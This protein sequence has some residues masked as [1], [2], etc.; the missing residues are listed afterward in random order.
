MSDTEET[1]GTAPEKPQ[2]T[3][4][5]RHWKGITA[6]TTI[7]TAGLLGGLFAPR[8][9]GE[10]PPMAP[11]K[12]PKE[13]LTEAEARLVRINELA[14]LIANTPEEAERETYVRLHQSE[15]VIGIREKRLPED[16]T[17]E[18]LQ[19]SAR[20][21]NAL[22]PMEESAEGKHE[23]LTAVQGFLKDIEQKT[24]IPTPDI[25]LGPSYERW[26]DIKREVD[27]H[28]EILIAA[29]VIEPEG[30][31]RTEWDREKNFDYVRDYEAAQ[32]YA[33]K[34][35]LAEMAAKGP[36]QVVAD[37]SVIDAVEL[38]KNPQPH[39]RSIPLAQTAGVT[40]NPFNPEPSQLMQDLGHV[41]VT[42]ADGEELNVRLNMMQGMQVMEGLMKNSDPAEWKAPTA[43]Q[44][45]EMQRAAD[46]QLDK[47]L[48][49]IKGASVTP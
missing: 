25:D 16:M 18:L 1:D 23:R 43:V 20:R 6:T 24:H 45:V 48:P 44:A 10:I 49:Y 22:H 15:H 28:E 11:I 5:R 2:K 12:I 21:F 14:Q 33:L 30:K 37:Q 39:M 32:G 8:D 46:Q 7:A 47:V 42:G 36:L 40:Y 31:T 27:P 34:N 29:G 17:N 19:E 9:V 3:F 4:L 13:N 35:K 41:R 38:I 26:R